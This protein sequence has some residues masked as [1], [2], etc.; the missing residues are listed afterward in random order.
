MQTLSFWKKIIYNKNNDLQKLN[1]NLRMKKLNPSYILNL[2]N[3]T[4][5]H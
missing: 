1:Y 4:S 3:Y 5:D 2:V